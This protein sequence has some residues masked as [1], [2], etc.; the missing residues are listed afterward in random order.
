MDKQLSALDQMVHN[1]D[2][3]PTKKPRREI[4]EED[5]DTEEEQ[6]VESS[7]EE[8]SDE[9]EQ[10]YYEGVKWDGEVSDDS[11]D[12]IITDYKR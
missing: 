11:D 5:S 4:A 6:P 10:P 9:D 2:E 7:E 1:L 3:N 8:S 12:D